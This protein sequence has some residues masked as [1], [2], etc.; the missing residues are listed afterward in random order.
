MKNNIENN[1]K[2]HPYSDPNIDRIPSPDPNIINSPLEDGESVIPLVGLLENLTLLNVAELLLII[3]IFIIIFSKNINGFYIKIIS[4]IVNKYIPIKYHNKINKYLNKGEKINDKFMNIML[5][6]NIFL[7]LI[8]ILGNLFISSHLYEN[9]DDYVLVYNYLKKIN[10]NSILLLFIYKNNKLSI[11]NMSKEKYRNRFMSTTNN[12][13]LYEDLKNIDLSNLDKISTKD[14]SSIYSY[15][16]QNPDIIKDNSEYGDNITPLNELVDVIFSYNMLELYLILLII[17][18]LFYR[19][20]LNI[21][22]KYIPTKFNYIIK[23]VESGINMNKKV[24]NVLLII[25]FFLL[26][27]FKLVN[28]IFSYDLHINLNEYIIV[29]NEIKKSSIL[30][31][32]SC[33]NI[34]KYSSKNISRPLPAPTARGGLVNKYIK[35]LNISSILLL[36]NN[37]KFLFYLKNN[38]TY[39]YLPLILLN[40]FG[41][42][43]GVPKDIE[44]F[45]DLTLSILILLLIVLFCFVR[46]VSYFYTVYLIDKYNLYE[47]YPKYQKIIKRFEKMRSYYVIAEI[48][49]CITIL[50]FIILLCLFVLYITIT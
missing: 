42:P 1:I 39:S 26:I 4:Y 16:L 33:N 17:Y 47:K 38:K 31:L 36:I 23:I 40:F 12:K 5:L 49:L 48:I 11:K 34:L 19:N 15:G 22:I 35:Y 8:F 13:L 46:I 7:L 28:I 32:L 44:P 20:I 2:D 9:I 45:F 37:I 43:K 21:I 10:K 50:I 6:I 27:I 18:I 30:I 29:Y 3:V 41:V 24:M 14:L 25:L